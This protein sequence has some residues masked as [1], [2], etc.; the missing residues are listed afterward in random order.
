MIE[1]FHDLGMRPVVVTAYL[2]ERMLL[3]SDDLPQIDGI[4]AKGRLQMM[5]E[6]QRPEAPSRQQERVDDVPIRVAKW[7]VR[8]KH[9]SLTDAHGRLW[10]YV[11]TEAAPVGDV[12]RSSEAI[13]KPTDVQAMARLSSSPSVNIGAADTK[14]YDLRFPTLHAA[15]L[16]WWLLGDRK[17]IRRRYLRHITSIGGKR[18]LG[19]GR[20][21]Q[22]SVEQSDVSAE[23]ILARRWMPSDVRS[24]RT[25]R[26]GVRPPYWHPA[27][28]LLCVEPEC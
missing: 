1:I 21:A 28:Q 15:A 7:G 17:E 3:K 8:S 6:P 9:A 25:A 19:F 26:R 2:A 4:L 24:G 16:R 11:V 23:W 5:P 14:S 18:G 27:R 12:V 20:V 10:G 22:W 13:R